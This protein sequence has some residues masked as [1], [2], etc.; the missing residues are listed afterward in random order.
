M[1]PHTADDS[2]SSGVCIVGAKRTPYGSFLGALS[3][4]SAPQLG[5]AAIRGAL[6]SAAV[7]PQDV[8]EVFMGNVLGA[9]VGQAPARQAALGAGLPA[10]TVCTTVNKV[11]ASGMK[12]VMLGALA[13]QS[14]MSSTVVAGG[15][16]SMSNAP[17]YL[18]STARSPG[19]RMGHATLTD[20]MIHDGLWDPYDNVHMGELAERCAESRGITREQQDEH[21][22]ESVGR[23]RAA[24]ASGLTSEELTAV[25]VEGTRGR[26]STSVTQD[27]PLSKAKPERLHDLKTVFRDKDK[28]GTITAGNASPITDGAAALV[29]MS[30]AAAEGRGLE[31][32][33][34][35]AGMADA[36]QAPCDFPTTP[37]LAVQRALQRARVNI[38]DVD[39]WEINEAFS[40]VDI[41]NRQ[42][43]GLDDDRVNVHGGSVALGHPIGASGAA[44]LV[45]LLNLM[46]SKGGRIGVAAI[47]NGGGG[48]SAV[49]LRR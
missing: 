42:L 14:G 45:R 30:T 9:G 2:F 15:M 24:Q 35:I 37:A 46:K 48:A 16:E 41:A 28:G 38:I 40:V 8:E 32:L 23:A 33:G 19:L 17:L 3:S 36:E 20:S 25:E 1:A 47:C 29:L 4:L 6:Q 43:L 10:P 21:A 39:F 11:C 26:A 22:E 13:V 7:D 31:I 44:I 18:P 34:H 49:V 12:A 27:E 5:A